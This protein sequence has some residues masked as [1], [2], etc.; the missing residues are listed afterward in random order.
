MTGVR[1]IFRPM[2]LHASCNT[3]WALEISEWWT[4]GLKFVWKHDKYGNKKIK[5]NGSS[6]K[7]WKVLIVPKLDWF[8]GN[9]L[10]YWMTR[11]LRAG[12][13]GEGWERKF[14]PSLP[15]CSHVCRTSVCTAVYGRKWTVLTV[16]L[17]TV[18]RT[19]KSTSVASPVRLRSP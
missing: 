18:H 3:R 8:R 2:S 13:V 7:V 11:L 9:C 5:F 19:V 14:Q 6:R 10:Y 17:R 16:S 4:S 1:I 12:K 15:R